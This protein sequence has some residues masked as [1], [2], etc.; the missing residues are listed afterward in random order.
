VTTNGSFPERVERFASRFP[1]P[2]RLWIAVSLDGLEQVHDANR[3]P[4]V[5]FDKAWETLKRLSRL[6]SSG[7]RF[8]VNY[9]V[10]SDQSLADARVIRERLNKLD[11]PMHTVLAYS[12]SSMYSADRA[13]R[14][15]GDLLSDAD[16]PLLE[17]ID[18]DEAIRFV[19]EEL[20]QA[21]QVYTGMTRVAKRYYLRGLLDRLCRQ[22]SDLKPRCAALRS[23]LR[24]LPDGQVPVCQFNTATIGNLAGQPFDAVWHGEPAARQ[25]R[26]ID[27]CPGC[28]A[29]CEVLPSAIYCGA[30]LRS[31]LHKR[32]PVA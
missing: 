30:L 32:T 29:E 20:R 25:R 22:P 19:T 7:V 16:Y 24:L 13:G 15:S 4:V 8:S 2:R 9:A 23:H 11:V 27:Q 31:V 26:W 14:P 6:R 12:A 17:S 18:R 5:T 28:W 21:A 10:I 1:H 3:G